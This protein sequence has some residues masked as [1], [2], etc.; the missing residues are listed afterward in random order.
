MPFHL[1]AVI[2][3]SSPIPVIT[4]LQIAESLDTTPANVRRKILSMVEQFPELK[5]ELVSFNYKE[6][7][8][9]RG[10]AMTI[11][12]LNERW[13][14]FL[15]ARFDN[16]RGVA[17]LRALI[18][19]EMDVVPELLA[20]VERLT[21]ELNAAK[22]QLA[23]AGT[24]KKRLS[25]GRKQALI[26]FYQTDLYGNPTLSH[27]AWVPEETASKWKVLEGKVQNARAAARGLLNKAHELEDEMNS[28]KCH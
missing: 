6:D 25:D 13:A 21:N 4:H 12:A 16:D 9:Q 19:L 23:D 8:K 18:G 3:Q 1:P 27:K 17:Y 11:Y 14:R 5:L 7:D 10:P 15:V 20:T 24:K 2:P 26:S 22:Q 28:G